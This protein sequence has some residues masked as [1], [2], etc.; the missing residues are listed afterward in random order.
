[1]KTVEGMSAGEMEA[2]FRALIHA[3]LG[4]CQ[5]EGVKKIPFVLVIP[6]VSDCHLLTNCHLHMARR[7]MV[8][9]MDQLNSEPGRDIK[10]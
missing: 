4:A 7:A 9:A 10:L 1:M 2:L 6:T 3:V 8:S 5:D